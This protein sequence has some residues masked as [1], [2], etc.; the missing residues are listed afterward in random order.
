MDI[1]NE[2]FKIRQR[3]LL[4]KIEVESDIKE[5]T[6]L[7]FKRVGYPQHLVIWF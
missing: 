4:R 2:T 6:L 1:R 7:Q 3:T 5:A